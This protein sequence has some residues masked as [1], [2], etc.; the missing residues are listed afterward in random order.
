MKGED[1]KKISKHHRAFGLIKTLIGVKQLKLGSV[2]LVFSLST[3]FVLTSQANATSNYDDYYHTTSSIELMSAD[4][5]C[6]LDI[7]DSWMNKLGGYTSSLQSAINNGGTYGVSELPR[8]SVDA[9]NNVTKKAV[10]VYWNTSYSVAKL[11]LYYRFKFYSLS[12]T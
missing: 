5:N 1:M 7:S 2:A 9:T 12:F 8:Y 6:S 11:G 4:L 10:I 3:S